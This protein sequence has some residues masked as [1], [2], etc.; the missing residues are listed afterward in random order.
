MKGIVESEVLHSV[1]LLAKVS[2][3]KHGLKG[4]ISK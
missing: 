3:H 2:R 1:I 4:G